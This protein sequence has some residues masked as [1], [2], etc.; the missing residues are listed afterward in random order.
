MDGWT[1]V[2]FR[3]SNSALLPP[4]NSTATLDVSSTIAI[5]TGFDGA[6]GTITINKN[7]TEWNECFAESG[8]DGPGI[9]LTGT[10]TKLEEIAATGQYVTVQ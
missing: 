2:L 8:A 4:S 5:W 6:Y 1:D 3:P 9:I 7:P 10:C